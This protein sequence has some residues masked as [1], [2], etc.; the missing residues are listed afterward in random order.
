MNYSA[1]TFMKTF[2]KCQ[3]ANLCTDKKW[4]SLVNLAQKNN[5]EWILG[6]VFRFI[7]SHKD[8]KSHSVQSIIKDPLQIVSCLRN[9][10]LLKLILE[11]EDLAEFNNDET[12]D[13]YRLCISHTIN[14]TNARIESFKAYSKILKLFVD[15]D[16]TYLDKL[17]Q[18]A[19]NS[20]DIRKILLLCMNSCT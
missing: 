18:L 10:K 13:Y 1:G 17:Y 16:K 14:R 15:F 19:E 8:L 3:Q 6:V 4:I 7:Y 5:L 12:K 20:P 9:V 2:A 11:K